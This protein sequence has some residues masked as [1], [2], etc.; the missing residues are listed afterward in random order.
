V[1]SAIKA[2]INLTTRRKQMCDGGQVLCVFDGI[3]TLG[4]MGRSLAFVLC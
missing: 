4:N 3:I 1:G 2:F